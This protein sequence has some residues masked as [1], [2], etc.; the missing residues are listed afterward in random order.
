MSQKA[1]ENPKNHIKTYNAFS[2]HA[3]MVFVYA[4]TFLMALCV[5][6]PHPKS[7]LSS[8][9]ISGIRFSAKI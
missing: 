3:T 9:V 5:L 4:F 1:V 6:V 2:D 7:P 8:T